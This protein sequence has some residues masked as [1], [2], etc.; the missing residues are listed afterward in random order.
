MSEDPGL[1]Y[2]VDDGIATITL[3]RPERMNAFTLLTIDAWVAALTDAAA[4]VQVRVVVVRA[5]GSA[6]CAGIDL[7]A[8]AALERTPIAR[9]EVLSKRIHRVA[10]ALDDLDKPTI[11]AINGPAV[12]AG[13]DMALLCDMR[14]AA[15]SARLGEGYIK[16]G[17]VPGDGG[18]WLLP[19]LVGPA[20][21]MELLMTG[22]FVD[23]LE[24][25]RLGLVNTVVDDEQLL[26]ATYALAR[27]IAAAPPVQ[28]AMI[29][30][31]VRQS[32]TVDLR[33]HLD[34]VSSHAGIVG[35]INDATAARP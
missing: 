27:R 7:A 6:F 18:A 8:L 31:L 20:K 13:L 21:A 11:A 2:A 3:D 17:L 22:D 5:T 32:G 23:A 14:I 16:V 24:A 30:R 34:L 9:K 25:E 10:L 12:G 33:T 29:R 26:D 35:S 28:I 4:D 1:R 15:R 19:R